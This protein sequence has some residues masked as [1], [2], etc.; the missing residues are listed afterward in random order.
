ML[1]QPA[2]GPSFLPGLDPAFPVQEVLGLMAA[3]YNSLIS[4]LGHV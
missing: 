3:G 2:S 4:E 1:R